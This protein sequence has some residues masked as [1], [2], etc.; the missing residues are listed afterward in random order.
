MGTT[1]N[2]VEA[3]SPYRAARD[4]LNN[5]VLP[6]NVRKVASGYKQAMVAALPE[7]GGCKQYS[8]FSV[9]GPR[10]KRER[11]FSFALDNACDE[12]T[13]PLVLHYIA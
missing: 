4:A 2:L 10:R 1:V 3:W 5:T 11:K 7:I 6:A 13:T 9:H 12:R 8:L